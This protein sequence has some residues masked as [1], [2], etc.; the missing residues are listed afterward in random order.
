MDLDTLREICL[1]HPGATEEVQ[2]EDHLLFKVGGKMF[3]IT[4]LNDANDTSFKVADEDFE[5]LSSS[6]L[7][8]PAPHLARAK[9]VKVVQPKALKL[10][11]WRK[12]I[13]Q[14]YRLVRAK[15]PK[16]V[17]ATLGEA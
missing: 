4:S 3:C 1:A 17:Q 10:V 9:W 12:H 15:L 16:K 6:D 8:M 14:S 7:F 2:W 5:E 13:G 11:D